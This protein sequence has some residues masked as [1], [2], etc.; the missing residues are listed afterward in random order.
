MAR[1]LSDEIRVIGLGAH[2]VV[3]VILDVERR[4]CWVRV[5]ALLADPEPAA[6]LPRPVVKHLVAVTEDGE[7]VQLTTEEVNGLADRF[8]RAYWRGKRGDQQS[9]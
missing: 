1:A 4:G 5:M 3:E 8:E 2:Q 7:L 9:R 6:G